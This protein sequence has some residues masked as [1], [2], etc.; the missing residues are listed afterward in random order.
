MKRFAFC[1]K[2]S[3]ALPLSRTVLS[4][5]LVALAGLG[6]GSSPQGVDAAPSVDSAKSIDAAARTF[7]AVCQKMALLCP[8]QASLDKCEAQSGQAF[9]LCERLP[10]TLGCTQVS[11]NTTTCPSK[12]QIC[13]TAEIS[14]GYCT[15]SCVND[16]DC[17]LGN[18][19]NGTCTSINGV[20]KICTRNQ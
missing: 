14:A 5:A 10:I 11:F 3:A 9:S 13:R 17:P 19:S 7:P 1:L 15:H 20:V 18:G 8:D 2:R 12:S 4:A 16:T 6:C